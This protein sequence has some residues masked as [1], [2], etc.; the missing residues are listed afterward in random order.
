MARFSLEEEEYFTISSAVSTRFTSEDRETQ[1]DG[2][3]YHTHTH[4]HTHK[5]I[6]DLK[7][8][9]NGANSLRKQKRCHVNCPKPTRTHVLCLIHNLP[10]Q[11]SWRCVNVLGCSFPSKASRPSLLRKKKLSAEDMQPK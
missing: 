5:L 8:D 6:C 3:S 11:I 4:T 10:G 9:T 7:P 2:Q 1:T